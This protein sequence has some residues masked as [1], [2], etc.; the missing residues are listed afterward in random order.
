[1][2][3]K[4]PLIGFVLMLAATCAFE[5]RVQAQEKISSDLSTGGEGNAAPRFQ[6]DLGSANQH[7]GF[8]CR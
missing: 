2:R 6:R 5:A 4:K 7:D 8:L 3:M 1:M